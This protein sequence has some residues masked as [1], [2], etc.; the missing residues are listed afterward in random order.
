MT[1]VYVN[2]KNILGQTCGVT[3][4]GHFRNS[5]VYYWDNSVVTIQNLTK[6]AGAG[7]FIAGFTENLPVYREA[8]EQLKKKYKI[9][10]QSPVRINT[11]TGR[12]FFFCIYDN[13]QKGS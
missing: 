13:T 6:P 9:V 1:K 3:E 12:E 11:R 8:Y 2:H 4:L 7:W 5:Q 10:Y